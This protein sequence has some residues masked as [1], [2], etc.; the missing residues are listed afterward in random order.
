MSEAAPDAAAADG[1]LSKLRTRIS[2]QPLAYLDGVGARALESLWEVFGQARSA[3]KNHPG[4][5]NFAKCTTKM[6]NIDLRPPYS[7]MTD[8]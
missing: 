4:C 3:M 5:V 1:L 2:T 7:E 6:L 8:H